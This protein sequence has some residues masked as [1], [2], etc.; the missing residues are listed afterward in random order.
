M[1]KMKNCIYFLSSSSSKS[2]LHAVCG[3]A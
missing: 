3:S 1:I 2:R